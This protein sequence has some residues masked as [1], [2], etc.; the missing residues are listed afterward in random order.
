MTL[1]AAPLV[2]VIIPTYNDADALI[3]CL[4]ALARQKTS[5]SFE[6]V[7]VSSG[8]SDSIP[9]TLPNLDLRIVRHEHR[10]LAGSARNLGAEYSSGAIL[11]FTDA[12][13][14]PDV[15]WIDAIVSSFRSRDGMVGGSIGHVHPLLPIPVADNILQFSDYLPGRPAGPS[16]HL[17][18]C[19]MAVR[20][21]VFAAVDGFPATGM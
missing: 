19:N 7:V 6:V 3:H 18:G 4:H 13:C 1:D 12:D 21:D 20:R 2:S 14:Q 17:A 9:E 11:A 8:R 10:L 5:T 16:D 15:D